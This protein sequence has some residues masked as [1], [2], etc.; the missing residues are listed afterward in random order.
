[1]VLWVNQTKD[2]MTSAKTASQNMDRSLH[3]SQPLKTQ[4]M[5]HALVFH[6]FLERISAILVIFDLLLELLSMFSDNS[7]CVMS[8]ISRL[9]P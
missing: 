8:D 7:N 3:T 6:S 5:M 9:K 1:M 2:E 4:Y